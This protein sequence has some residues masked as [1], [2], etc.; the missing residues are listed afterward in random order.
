MRLM[1]PQP[2]GAYTRWPS[3]AGS[4]P[5]PDCRA[6]GS[7]VPASLKS[8]PRLLHLPRVRQRASC[9]RK[10]CGGGGSIIYYA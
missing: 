4:G 8:R 6:C 10:R 7:L 9:A 2:E 3:G 5:S 1:Q